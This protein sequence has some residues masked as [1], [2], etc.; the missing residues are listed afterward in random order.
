MSLEDIII[1]EITEQNKIPFLI[2]AESDLIPEGLRNHIGDL[3]HSLACKLN[4]EA[5]LDKLV[6]ADPYK[7]ESPGA[8]HKGY[9]DKI[10]DP[11]LTVIRGQSAGNGVDPVLE[12]PRGSALGRI[13]GSDD[14]TGDHK[15]EQ[16]AQCENHNKGLNMH[17]AE[18][19]KRCGNNNSH[20]LPAVHKPHQF[21]LL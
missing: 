10:G 14:K 6:I 9:L 21:Q 11:L 7:C 8:S 20:D 5:L 17:L 12:Y 1:G 13:E 2:K 16:H 4:S 15:N 18:N 19:T 3:F